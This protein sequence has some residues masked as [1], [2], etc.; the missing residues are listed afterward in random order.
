MHAC[1][2]IPYV[3]TASLKTQDKKKE[4][5]KAARKL[6][7]PGHLKYKGRG[8]SDRKNQNLKNKTVKQRERER[9][10]VCVLNICILD[11]VLTLQKKS[12]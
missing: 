8:K 3:D 11:Q 5:N 7:E 4:R 2:L 6:F 1:L 12:V 9:E 10:S